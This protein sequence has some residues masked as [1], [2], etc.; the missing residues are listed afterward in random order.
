MEAMLMD[1]KY[2]AGGFPKIEKAHCPGTHLAPSSLCMP[3]VLATPG[4]FLAFFNPRRGIMGEMAFIKKPIQLQWTLHARA[5]MN[6]YRLTPARVRHV[7]HSPKRV[8]EGVAPKTVAM[9]QPVS[10]KTAAGR[11]GGDKKES[12]T[13]EIWVMVQD[14]AGVRKV[15]SAWRYPGVT[16]AR[17]AV[18]LKK[19][20]NEFIEKSVKMKSFGQYGRNIYN[21]SNNA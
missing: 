15:I 13:Q 18:F 6:H 4:I 12:W 3:D 2:P 11:A 7:L 1:K 19:E 17:D 9:M 10:F 8:E 20:Y 5:K 14:A 21:K 16:K